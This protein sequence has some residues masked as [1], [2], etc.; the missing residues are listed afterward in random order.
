MIPQLADSN[1]CTGCGSC[2]NACHHQAL[3]MKEDDEGF[4]Y[5]I[6]DLNKCIECGVCSKRCPEL[7]VVNNAHNRI[8][9]QIYA[10]INN[11]D[12]KYSSSGGAFSAF[13]RIIIAKGGVVY[14]AILD[15]HNNC[16][17]KAAH[18]IED[19]SPLRGSKYVQSEID[20]CY[21][22]VKKNLSLGKYVMF[23]GTPCQVSGLKSYLNKDYEKLLAIDV[24]CHGVPSNRLFKSYL[25][26]LDKKLHLLSGG[27]F[28]FRRLDG[29][30]IASSISWGNKVLP[31]Y[32]VDNLYMEAF[33]KC[34][35]FRKSCYQCR[36]AKIPRQGD[37]TIADFW[38]IGRHGNSF[39][40]KTNKGVSL[41]MVND[42]KGE[43]FISSL[44]G[45][46]LEE[47]TIQEAIIENPN[48]NKSSDK[49]EKRDDIVKAIIDSEMTLDEIEAQFHLT[50]NS[51]K[52][53]VKHI[54]QRSG[55]FTVIKYIY[56]T[57]KSL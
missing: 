55:L 5:P 10:L 39:S 43:V 34:A 28:V 18:T 35:I 2:V 11:I 9:P 46:V 50:D 3:Q 13:A 15:S 42:E 25:E 19:I 53:M 45:C 36:Y 8:T 57:Y 20:L 4:L 26:K 23:T 37:I 52:G 48:V 33:N 6:L 32:G 27:K 29:W 21:Q 12:K 44:S 56:D 40:Y 14:G 30:G 31:L 38:G 41:V 7:N 51:V 49:P 54:A 47:R 17:H 16:I 1:I 24:V 22:E